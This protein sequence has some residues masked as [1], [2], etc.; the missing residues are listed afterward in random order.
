MQ[1]DSIIPDKKK[2]NTTNKTALPSSV[3]TEYYP[4]PLAEPLQPKA[5]SNQQAH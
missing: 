2:P 3:Y 1:M 4:H 5:S